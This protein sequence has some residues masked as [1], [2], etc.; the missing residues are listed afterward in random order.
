MAKSNNLSFREQMHKM[1]NLVCKVKPEFINKFDEYTK[2]L[3]L[4]NLHAF[5][6]RKTD[7]YIEGKGLIYAGPNQDT[8]ESYIKSN[9]LYSFYLA[10]DCKNT[11]TYFN[12]KYNCCS[13]ATI[14]SGGTIGIHNSNEINNNNKIMAEEAFIESYL[15]SRCKTLHRVTSNFTIFSLI[16][17]PKQPFV[18]LSCM[19]KNEIIKEH[20]L[21]DIYLEDFLLK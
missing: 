2:K 13:Y 16:V 19:F 11:F 10:T 8:I 14:R 4:N 6:M 12:N 18:D 21:N 17:N 1:Y 5:H 15:L 20:K 9:S 3:N 7:R